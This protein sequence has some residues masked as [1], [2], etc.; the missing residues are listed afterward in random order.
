MPEACFPS[1]FFPVADRFRDRYVEKVHAGSGRMRELDV[2]ICGLA[3][4]VEHVLPSTIAHVETLGA[5]F[6]SYA[7]ATLKCPLEYS[8]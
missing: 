1:S 7:A 4:D 5:A 2:V 3:R 6:R 8:L